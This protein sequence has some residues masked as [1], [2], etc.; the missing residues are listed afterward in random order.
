L[1]DVVSP[2]PFD[3]QAEESARLTGA[4]GMSPARMSVCVGL[5]AA[6]RPTGG[7]CLRLRSGMASWGPRTMCPPCTRT[8]RLAMAAFLPRLTVSMGRLS[9]SPWGLACPS[10]LGARRHGSCC[11]PHWTSATDAHPTLTVPSRAAY[12]HGSR[13]CRLWSSGTQNNDARSERLLHSSSTPS[14]IYAEQG[15]QSCSTHTPLLRK[16]SGTQGSLP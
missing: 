5:A 7:P 12:L 13:P 9:V 6:V 1:D 4:H 10:C 2:A 16:P 14:L 3:F 8:Q 11:L 15:P